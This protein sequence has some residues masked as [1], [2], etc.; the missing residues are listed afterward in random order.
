MPRIPG[1]TNAQSKFLR[2]FYHHPA[3]PAKK[4]WPSPSILRRWLSKPSFRAALAQ[5]KDNCRHR[6]HVQLSFSTFKAAHIIAQSFNDPSPSIEAQKS[7]LKNA[8]SLLQLDHGRQ[9]FISRSL[10]N[11]EIARQPP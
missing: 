5:V 8:L 10:A 7:K 11:G 6:A 2:A 4:S 9:R 1:T 3:G